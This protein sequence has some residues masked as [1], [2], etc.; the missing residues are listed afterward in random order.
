MLAGH[1]RLAVN[2]VLPVG[3]GIAGE[4]SLA[5]VAVLP[6]GAIVAVS[7]VL[8]VRPVCTFFLVVAAGRHFS[9]C[10]LKPKWQRPRHPACKSWAC[11]SKQWLLS[12]RTIT[13]RPAVHHRKHSGRACATV[14]PTRHGPVVA[15]LAIQ[16]ALASRSTPA[17]S[18]G[19]SLAPVLP[20][21]AMQF[22]QAC[23]FFSIT[24]IPK[25]RHHA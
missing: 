11:T 1:T 7:A 10:T 20:Q 5:I 23:K 24:P 14:D 4:A 3:A 17:T 6:G 2:A 8:R 21:T 22:S 25:G 16:S 13:V 19:Y 18:S 15:S 9:Y 12:G